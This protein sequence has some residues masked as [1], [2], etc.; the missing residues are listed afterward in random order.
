MVPWYTGK[1]VWQDK[2]TYKT[3]RGTLR[4]MSTMTNKCDGRKVS[5]GRRSSSSVEEDSGESNMGGE[6]HLKKGPWTSAE[7]A[8]LVDYVKK[9][10]EGNWN[11]VQR[12][13]GLV[14]KSCRIRWA[15]HLR[16]DLRKG[17]FTEEEEE[18]RIIELHAKM[19]NKWAR[20]AAEVCSS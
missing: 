1:K 10:R 12:H 6:G 8:I 15:N 5:K 3:R 17:A 11:A 9:H 16:P 7:D 4:A 18:R 2:G 20:M 14:G 13:S 19:G